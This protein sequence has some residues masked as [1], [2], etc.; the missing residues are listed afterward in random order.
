MNTALAS[1]IPA[2]NTPAA[3]K[4]SGPPGA[5]PFS[6]RLAVGL[7]GVL[8]AAMMAGL[9]NRVPELTLLDLRGHL[10]WGADSASWLNTAYSAGELVAMPF[11]T[12]FAITLSLRR[13]LIAMV[14]AAITIAAI[15]PWIHN[16]PLMMVLR[17]FQGLFSGA[18]IPLLMMSALRFLPPPIRLHG[19]ALYALTATFSPN[20]ALW[21]GAQWLDHLQDWHWVFWHVIPV[22]LL[23]ICC[24][25]WGIPKMPTAFPRFRQGNWAGC[26]LGAVGLSL[27]V[28]GLDQGTRLDWFNS[29]LITASLI[30]GACITT[31]FLITEWF[32]PTPFMRLQLLERRNLGVNF[33]VFL[34]LLIV[35]TGAVGF[36]AEM[37]SAMHTFRLEQTASLGL[38][39]GL[40]QLV[41]GPLVALLLYRK[42][43]DARIT[44][45]LG[46]GCMA[47]ACWMGS[48]ITEVWMVHQ[49]VGAEL[50]QMIGQPLAVI[51]ALFL[52]TSV[53][54]PM[55]G[56]Y[57]AGI[58]NTIR[59]FGTVFGGALISRLMTVRGNFHKEMLLDQL[60]HN[61]A[62]HSVHD[63]SQ[64][65]SNIAEQ[66][67]ILA[68]ADIY[69]IFA[70]I[71]L[72]L[73]PVVLSLQYIPAPKIVPPPAP[74]SKQ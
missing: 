32:H 7:L 44:Y 57:V 72:V 38:I 21:L 18:L 17:A 9:D 54:Q 43:A 66:A 49:F 65:A 47:L 19:L 34:G 26:A 22:G 69:R 11:S 48:G 29:P 42:W 5:I 64:L 67:E 25:A 51:S 40:P 37:L 45:A 68:S 70:V 2:G 28:V 50:L 8:L 36:P 4:P 23:A 27:L 20:I 73:I 13:F 58:I 14:G 62:V 30:G 12:W 10:G 6:G 53:V 3:A 15:L 60:G 74:P 35:M 31:L 1:A 52:G 71:A 63:F 46:L 55:E 16:L 61:Q 24:V 56:P 59:A 33:S 39:V 41:L